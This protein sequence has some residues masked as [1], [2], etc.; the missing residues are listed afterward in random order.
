LAFEEEHADG[1]E[2]DGL[3][4]RRGRGLSLL[5]CGFLSLDVPAEEL[6]KTSRFDSIRLLLVEEEL[7]DIHLAGSRRMRAGSAK[8][9]LQVE[10]LGCRDASGC[11]E[12]E[13]MRS[14]RLQRCRGTSSGSLL[15][16]ARAVTAVS[17]VLPTPV[18]VDGAA[19]PGM[20]RVVTVCVVR[21]D[22]AHLTFKVAHN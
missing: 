7:L 8:G 21:N 6:I 1:L 19:E 10:G 4:R 12:H 3:G 20:S 22:D 13:S 16:L 2:A 11:T 9:V 15:R 5:G 14:S 18:Q 17:L